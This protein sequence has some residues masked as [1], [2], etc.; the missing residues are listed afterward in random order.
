MEVPP[1]WEV[2]LTDSP[3]MFRDTGDF[4]ITLGNTT[5]RL[6]DVYFDSPNPDGN[7]KLA[8]TQQGPQR[9]TAGKHDAIHGLHRRA[10]D[11]HRPVS[12]IS[13]AAIASTRSD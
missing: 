5:W 6:H 2:W 4:S 1:G 13:T 7:G 8:P 12:A 10:S 9:R 3:P 11:Q